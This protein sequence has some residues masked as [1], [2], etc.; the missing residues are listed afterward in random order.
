MM[1]I[2]GTLF[3]V[4]LGASAI[5][6]LAAY[7]GRRDK[8]KAKPSTFVAMSLDGAPENEFKKL[9]RELEAGEA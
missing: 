5:L 7:L 1:F 9:F 8:A 6:G 2:L 3:G 4:V